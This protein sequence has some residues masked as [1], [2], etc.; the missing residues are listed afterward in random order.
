LQALTHPRLRQELGEISLVPP[1]ERVA[2]PGSTPV[3]AAFTHLN[4][5]GSRFSDGSWG[6]YYAASSLD[7]AVAEV[8]FHCARFMT[9]TQQPRFI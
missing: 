7:T 9:E 1:A 6:V 8:G 3:M 4:P 5:R 2:G